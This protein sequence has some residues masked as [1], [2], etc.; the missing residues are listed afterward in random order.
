MNASKDKY[1]ELSNQAWFGVHEPDIFKNSWQFTNQ[2]GGDPK[3][4]DSKQQELH[5]PRPE[6]EKNLAI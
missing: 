2:K 5:M 4:D 1:R 6:T 3:K